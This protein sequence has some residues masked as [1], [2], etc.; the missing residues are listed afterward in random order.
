M[1]YSLHPPSEKVKK[2]L[3]WISEMVSQEPDAPRKKLLQQAEVRFD[4]SP[5]DCA[6]LE[7]NFSSSKGP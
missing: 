7:K 2:A 1:S 5:A 6:F 4:L 3:I